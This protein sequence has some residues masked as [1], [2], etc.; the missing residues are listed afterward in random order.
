MPSATLFCS[1]A[2][3]PRARRV[4]LA[5]AVLGAGV[6]AVLVVAHWDMVR[7]HVE[8]WYF[9]LTRETET[10]EYAAYKSMGLETLIVDAMASN[11]HVTLGCEADAF[12]LLLG[13]ESGG[14]VIVAVEDLSKEVRWSFDETQPKGKL[15]GP[16]LPQLARR[17]LESNGFRVLEQRFPRRA[18]VVIRHH[19]GVASLYSS[20]GEDAGITLEITPTVLP[21][22]PAGCEQKAA[23]AE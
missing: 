14:P 17:I 16:T 8:A 5:A 18:Y 21:T 9:Q 3:K 1:N 20:E 15:A 11:P 7:D 22:V 6:I 23:P 19:P 12:L 4:T 13:R 10:V 2:M